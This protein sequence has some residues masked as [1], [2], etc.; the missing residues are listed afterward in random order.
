MGLLLAG[1]VRAASCGAC[2]T[3]D[4]CHDRDVALTADEVVAI[5]RTL[6]VAPER[7][8]RLAPVGTAASGGA[9]PVTIKLSRDGPGHRVVLR[10]RDD[11]EGRTRC[12]FLMTAGSG[13]KLCGLGELAPGACRTFPRP[14]DLDAERRAVG[15]WRRWEDLTEDGAGELA[16]EGVREAAMRARD[17]A[18]IAR[19]DAVV[20]LREHRLPE[21]AF[22]HA[23]LA[24]AEVGAEVRGAEGLLEAESRS[25]GLPEADSRSGCA[26]CA[27]ARCCV[28]FDPEMTGH[29][30]HRLV[31]GLGLEAA[32]VCELKPTHGGQAGE[33]GIRLGDDQV[34]DL[35]LRRTGARAGF[36]GPGGRKRCG[37]LMD[38][39][40]EEAGLPGAARCGVY[41][42]RPLVCRLFPSDLTSFGVMVGSPIGVCPPD[43]WAQERADLV[44]LRT[45]HLIARRER[46]I[47]RAFVSRWNTQG[48][49]LAGL[50]SRARAARLTETLLTFHD[51]L[52]EREGDEA[53]DAAFE[54]ALGGPV[55][56]HDGAGA[57]EPGGLRA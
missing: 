5:A 16:A 47:F 52:G 27:T 44:T 45:L 56:E 25:E 46:A 34:W 49:R 13:R 28:I 19:W 51:R 8:A 40:A 26:T 3:R 6:A 1:G 7:F 15:C 36:T 35:R 12:V 48:E 23:L 31:R 39:S 43:A 29:D 17:E 53:I 54:A 57:P 33:D 9:E 38:L 22:L 50:D 18:A 42:E 24:D 2:R 4:C 32:D 14:V 20:A 30:L 11:G 37:L 21:D 55:A 10:R 41:R